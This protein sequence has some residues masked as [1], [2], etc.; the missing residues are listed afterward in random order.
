MLSWIPCFHGPCP[1]LS[2][3]LLLLLLQAS[4]A[5]PVVGVTEGVESLAMLVKR[6]EGLSCGLQAPCTAAVALNVQ[7]RAQ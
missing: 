3:T 2:C 1:R 7:V 4:H 5:D 6:E